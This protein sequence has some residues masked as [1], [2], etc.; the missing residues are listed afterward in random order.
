MTVTQMRSQAPVELPKAPAVDLNLEV[1][2]I[3]VSDVDRAKN[4]TQ[5]WAGD[6]MQTMPRAITTA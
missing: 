4:S 6:W 1:V 2:V 5:A 3:P